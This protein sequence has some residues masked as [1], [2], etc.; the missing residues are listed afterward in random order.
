M[1]DVEGYA[2]VRNV[3]TQDEMTLAEEGVRNLPKNGAGTRNLLDVAWCRDLAHRIERHRT[4]SQGVLQSL[5]AI[6]CTIFDKGVVANWS[7]ALHQDLA[8]PVKDQVDHPMLGVWTKKEG[9]HFIQ[10]PAELLGAMLAV[11]IHIDDCDDQN[12]PLRVVPRSHLHGR[13]QTGAA[14]ELRDQLGEITCA[15]KRGDGLLFRPLLLHASS[16]AKQPRH[17]RVLHFLFGPRYPGYGLE[18]S[19]PA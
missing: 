19:H 10:A 18:W 1:L 12:G 9:R 8:I 7:V 4:L 16:K 11:R 15:A 13:L 5:V 14:Q 6:Q 2:F 3:L 17:R